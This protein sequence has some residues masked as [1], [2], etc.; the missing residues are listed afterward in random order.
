MELV[1]NKCY[2]GYGLS[3]AAKMK[4]LEKKGIEVFPYI[5][6]KSDSIFEL[7]LKRISEKETISEERSLFRCIYYFQKDPVKDEFVNAEDSTD[8]NDFDFDD[9]KRF[10]KDLVE[11][12]KE[13]GKSA[14]SQFASLEIVEIPDG[15]SFE[16]SDYDGIET[17]HFGFQT[18]SV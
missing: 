13:L 18:G 5:P 10:D 14:N 2:G 15:T 9:I 8:Y 6:I 11:T 16:I 17:A 12:V 4:I 7:S 1:L 3:H